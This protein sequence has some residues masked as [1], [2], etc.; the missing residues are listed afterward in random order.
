MD[1]VRTGRA[2]GPVNGTV[3][4]HEDRQSFMDLQDSEELLGGTM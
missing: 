2:R 4:D 3:E 1:P